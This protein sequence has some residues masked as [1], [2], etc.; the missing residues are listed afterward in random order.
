MSE[1]RDLEMTAEMLGE[2]LRIDKDHAYGLIRF[3]EERGWVG[4]LGNMP[5]KNKRGRGATIYRIPRDLGARIKALWDNGWF[6]KD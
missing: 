1:I 4:K 3:G 2:A 5:A 6:P